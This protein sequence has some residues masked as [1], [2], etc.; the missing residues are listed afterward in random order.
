MSNAFPPGEDIIT[1]ITRRTA[2][3]GPYPLALV[4]K[5]VRSQ[6]RAAAAAT[7][8]HAQVEISGLGYLCLS[9]KRLKGRLS[10]AKRILHAYN[11]QL[12]QPLSQTRKASLARRIESIKNLIADHESRLERTGSGHL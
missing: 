4:E 7:A 9:P 10:K 3:S 12:T 2:L 1:L 6:F 11:I 8:Q 5:L